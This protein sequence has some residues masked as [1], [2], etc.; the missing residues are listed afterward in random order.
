MVGWILREIAGRVAFLIEKVFLLSKSQSTLKVRIISKILRN[1]FGDLLDWQKP[2][3]KNGI[4]PSKPD[5]FDFFDALLEKSLLETRRQLEA[6]SL[7]EIEN[8]YDRQGRKL[9]PNHYLDEGQH[10]AIIDR[11][12]TQEPCWFAGGFGV[13]G[14]VADFGYWLKMDTWSFEEALALSLGV[15]PCGDFIGDADRKGCQKSV[16]EFAIKRSNLI[17]NCFAWDDPGLSNGVPVLRLCEWFNEVELEIPSDI[18]V[19]AN[20]RFK[21]KFRL[22]RSQKIERE[23]TFENREKQSL[24][25]IMISM[26]LDFKGFDPK[27]I[28][29]PVVADIAHATDLAGLSVSQETIR[30]YINEARSLLPEEELVKLDTK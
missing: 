20:R 15:E 19:L 27:E 22:V 4:G 9:N 30:K 13:E 14:R 6:L 21:R 10:N 23:V 1:R 26:A 5:V 2:N 3:I 24:L 12:R 18:L 16:A 11:L 25:K 28:R 7:E 17:Q 29:S 8:D